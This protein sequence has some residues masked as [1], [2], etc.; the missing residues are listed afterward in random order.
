MVAHCRPLPPE[1]PTAMRTTRRRR[2]TCT[3]VTKSRDKITFFSN[4]RVPYESGMLDGEVKLFC[5][6]MTVLRYIGKKCP[7]TRIF[8]DMEKISGVT[9]LDPTATFFQR[10]SH[11]VQ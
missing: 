9:H 11:S 8:E 7:K 1:F 5:Q 10:G 6:S 4:V 2:V 3:L